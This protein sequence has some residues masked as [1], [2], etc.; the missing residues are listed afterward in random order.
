VAG[1][2]QAPEQLGV[3]VLGRRQPRPSTVITSTDRRLSTV[4][5]K[6]RV[7]YPIPPPSRGP[8]LRDGADWHREAVLLARGVEL[9]EQHA[10]V[11]PRDPVPGSIS[12][13]FISVVSIT[14]PPSGIAWPSIAWPPERSAIETSLSTA[15]WTAVAMSSTS[16]ARTINAGLRSTQRAFGISRA[17]S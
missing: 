5:P 2:A 13:R 8:G 1:A 11:G 12:I 16:V 9:A 17:S 10:G 14:K 6:R 15:Y 7:T 3:L 4:I